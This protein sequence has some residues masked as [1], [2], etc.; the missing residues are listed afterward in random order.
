MY[1]LIFSWHHLPHPQPLFQ[2]NDGGKQIIKGNLYSPSLLKSYCIISLF[3]G[4]G[5]CLHGSNSIII[6]KYIFVGKRNEHTE[7]IVWY[8]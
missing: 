8:D 3:M 4:G 5:G 7:E 1:F 2:M 6:T